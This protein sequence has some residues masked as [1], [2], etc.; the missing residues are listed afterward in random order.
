MANLKALRQRIRSVT[1]TRQITKAMKMVAAAKLRRSQERAF[2]T[3]DYSS[4]MGDMVQSIAAPIA[5]QSDAQSAP[6]LL[7]GRGAS[8]NGKRV[9]LLVFTADRGLCGSFN[10]SV[11]RSV[12][13]KIAEMHASGFRVS[14]TFVGRKGN[15][16]LKRQFGDLTRRVHV[17]MGKNLTF[18]KSEQEITQP[19]LKDFDDEE[20]DACFMVFNTFQ[21]AMVQTLTW[22][23]LIPAPVQSTGEEA[24]E[25]NGGGA[26]SMPPTYEPEEEEILA[27]LLPRNIAVQIFQALV[28]S[29]A[30]ENGSRMTAMDNAVRNAGSMLKRLNITYNRTRQAAITTELME[31][32]SGSESLK[33]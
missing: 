9:E 26:G 16:V 25:E 32:I 33:G 27:E 10:S 21:S 11:I 12:R 13:A 29:E 15:D 6:P 8:D 7:M 30:S 23:Q 17:G 28:E 2:A 24:E 4:R 5:A 31:I 18:E 22:Q 19:L 14:L 20:F 1:S 3:R